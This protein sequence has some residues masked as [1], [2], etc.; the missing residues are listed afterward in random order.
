MLLKINDFITNFDFITNKL[1][2]I[3]FREVQGAR[4]NSI[5]F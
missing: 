5:N 4:K 3:S 2:F 1:T